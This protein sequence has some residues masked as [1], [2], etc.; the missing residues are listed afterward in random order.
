MNFVEPKIRN[1][2]FG[3]SILVGFT[4]VVYVLLNGIYAPSQPY[5]IPMEQNANNLIAIAI[6]VAILPL[7]IIEYY[8]NN[9]LKE[10]DSHLPRLLMDITESIQAGLSLYNAL[11]EACKYD[12]GPISRY[13]DAAM[14]NF[15]VTSDFTGSMK[16]LGEKLKRP[17]AKRLVT[18]LIEADETGGKIDDV[19]D[20]SIDLFTNLDEYRQERDQQIGPYVLLVYIGTVIFLIISWTIITQFLLPIIEVSQQEH[21]SGSGLLSHLLSVDYYKSALFWASVIEG[22][23]GGLVAGKIMYGRINGGLIHSVVLIMISILFFNLLG[24]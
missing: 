12:Y 23:A 13:L 19:L 14:V 6:L 8:N 24:V 16:W 20:T 15:R 9:W 21:V 17:N 11:G 2:V 1:I 7:S 4:I 3:A 5:F 10:V 22:I 18:I